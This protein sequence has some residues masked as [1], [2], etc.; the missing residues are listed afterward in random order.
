MTA[1]DEPLSFLFSTCVFNTIYIGVYTSW[2]RM[3]VSVQICLKK[4]SGA[5]MRKGQAVASKVCVMMS[6]L[7]IVHI[8]L[9]SLSVLEGY[10]LMVVIVK[11]VQGLERFITLVLQESSKITNHLLQLFF[12][13]KMERRETRPTH[14]IGTG[15]LTGVAGVQRCLANGKQKQFGHFCRYWAGC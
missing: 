6:Q 4:I 8:S 14:H 13:Y 9:F 3:K 2:N 12:N 5:S 11:C 10:N 7:H 15:W 1:P